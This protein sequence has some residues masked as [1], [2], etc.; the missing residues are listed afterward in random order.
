M[1]NNI[2]DV[3]ITIKKVRELLKS[4]TTYKSNG[5]DEVHSRFMKELAEHL[6]YPGII[7][8]NVSLAEDKLPPLWKS[9]NV[10]CIFKSGDKKSESN[11]IIDPL[12]LHQSYV[13]YGD[14][15]QKRFGVSLCRQNYF[16]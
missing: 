10:T 11:V 7:L 2:C 8:F 5:P 1:N 13:H 4:V 9:V 12:A 16:P 14:S 15:D 6:A 3:V